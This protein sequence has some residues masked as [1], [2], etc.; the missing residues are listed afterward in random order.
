MKVPKGLLSFARQIRHQNKDLRYHN[1]IMWLMIR[2]PEWVIQYC[3]KRR[4]K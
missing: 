2:E 3:N 4:R 1:Y